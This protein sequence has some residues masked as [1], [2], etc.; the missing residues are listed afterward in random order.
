MYCESGY[1]KHMTRN[2]YCFSNFE[3]VTNGF[4]TFGDG[5]KRKICGK[6]TVTIQGLTTL[7]NVLYVKGL[8]ANLISIS[9][10]CDDDHTMQFTKDLCH[11]VNKQGQCLMTGQCSSDNCYLLV[12]Q[13]VCHNTV[14]NNTKLWHNKL[15]HL[16]YKDLHYLSK[17]ENAHGIPKLQLE[18]GK[19]C[20]PCQQGKQTKNSQFCAEQGI[21]HEFLAPKTP[22]QNGVMEQ[23]TRTL[24]GMTR[25][26]INVKNISKR[27]WAEA[28]NKACY[29]CNRIHLRPGTVQTPYEI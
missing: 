18:Q 27:L 10:M 19:V 2:K 20:G 8:K 28:I 24:Q 13:Y 29:I 6:G 7:Q 21:D 14:V 9:Q 12:N 4:V 1:S 17:H 23:K 5:F 3:V 22:Q 16:N 15:E 25:M 26:M 11:V